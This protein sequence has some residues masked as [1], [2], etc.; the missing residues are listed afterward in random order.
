M[1][2]RCHIVVM[3]GKIGT[4]KDTVANYLH[5]NYG[6]VPLSFAGSLKTV[7]A[8]L[9]NWDIKILEASTPETRR[10]RNELPPRTL[11]NREFNA[12]TALQYIGT[13]LFR[14]N[15]G[16]D[17][18]VDILKNKIE[19]LITENHNLS[20]PKIVI[21]DCRFVNEIKML[22]SYD[23][24]FICLYKN[25]NDLEPQEGEHISEHDFLHKVDMMEKIYNNHGEVTMDNLYQNI[26]IFLKNKN[27]N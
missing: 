5:D 25:N 14:N 15:F 4:G 11:C 6:F 2:K 10:Q 22:E 26:E 20:L 19:D 27:I 21:T 16:P 7:C 8:E 24:N 18:W 13:D 23:A 3:C 12:R 9:F 1:N 17:I